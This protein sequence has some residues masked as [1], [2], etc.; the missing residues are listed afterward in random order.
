M[1]ENRGLTVFENITVDIS[2]QN[3]HFSSTAV[4]LQ[5]VTLETLSLVP[6]EDKVLR[7]R[8]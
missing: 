3:S 6:F 8:L 4:Y 7:N 2:L 1:F 5:K